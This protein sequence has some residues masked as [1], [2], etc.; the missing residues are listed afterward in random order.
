MSEYWG[1]VAGGERERERERVTSVERYWQDVVA[2]ISDPINS[3][4]DYL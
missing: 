2:S 4:Y 1:A 3:F